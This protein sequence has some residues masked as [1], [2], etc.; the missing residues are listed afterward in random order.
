MD[1]RTG[2][3]AFICRICPLCIAQRRWPHS[4]FAQRMASL[5]GDCPACRA[6]RHRQ[7]E[8]RSPQG[9]GE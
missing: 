5:E 9:S 7:R 3:L 2:V 1:F 8:T 6:Y 4:A